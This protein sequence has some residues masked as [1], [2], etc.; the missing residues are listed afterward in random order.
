MV[1]RNWCEKFRETLEN[2]SADLK[3]IKEGLGGSWEI[4][5]V[6]ETIDEITEYIDELLDEY[7]GKGDED[8]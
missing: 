1:E 2:I 5:E 6:I 4:W 7:D 3:D 8:D